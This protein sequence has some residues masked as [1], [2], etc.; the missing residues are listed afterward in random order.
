MYYGGEVCSAIGCMQRCSCDSDLRRGL[1][2]EDFRKNYEQLVKKKQ[3]RRSFKRD[4]LVFRRTVVKV[5]EVLRVLSYSSRLGRCDLCLERVGVNDD[6]CSS[7][8]W[9]N[10]ARAVHFRPF[11]GFPCSLSYLAWQ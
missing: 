10:Y 6:P 4:L 1:A 3:D 2:W 11:M 9:L 5:G 7:Y 8:P